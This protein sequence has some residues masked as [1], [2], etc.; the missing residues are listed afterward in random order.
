[1]NS[2]LSCFIYGKIRC[3]QSSVNLLTTVSKLNDGCQQIYWR[4]STPINA[5][6]K[7]S[8]SYMQM[9]IVHYD[10]WDNGLLQQ[11][12]HTGPF[13]PTIPMNKEIQRC[14][15]GLSTTESGCI[16]SENE[17]DLPT[18]KGV[19]YSLISSGKV[20]LWFL[21]EKSRLLALFLCGHI[22]Y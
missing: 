21:T 22:D 12:P 2:V 13:H 4:L 11:T 16:W 3:W 8:T 14:G 20:V 19:G 5:Y 17:L 10:W 18:K 9:E 1:M 7:A 15:G 6:C